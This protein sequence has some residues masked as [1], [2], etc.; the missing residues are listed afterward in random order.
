MPQKKYRLEVVLDVR[1]QKKIKAAQFLASRRQ[2]LLDAEDE[3]ERRKGYLEDCRQEIIKLNDK[4]MSELDIGTS[5]GN[6]VAHRDYHYVLKEKE[7]TIELSIAEQKTNVQL[8][9][10]NVEDAIDKLADASKE[11]K[12]IEKH[13]KNWSDNKKRESIKKEQKLSDEIGAILHQHSEKL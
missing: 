12:V 6:L 9:E 10:N 11:L 3:L 4:M 8:A 13:K 7:E 2:E 5:A 1:G